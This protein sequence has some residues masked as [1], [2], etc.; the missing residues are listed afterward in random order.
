MDDVMGQLSALLVL[1]VAAVEFSIGLAFFVI[2]FQ[3]GG[4]I[5]V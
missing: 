3:V 5:S 4:A 1:M 2:T